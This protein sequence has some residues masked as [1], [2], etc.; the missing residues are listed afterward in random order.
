MIDLKLIEI[1]LLAVL[2]SVIVLICEYLFIF[3]FCKIPKIVKIRNYVVPAT[4][5]FSIYF[6]LPPYFFEQKYL[7]P[8]KIYENW[9]LCS[10]C[11]IAIIW[12][13]GFLI[14]NRIAIKNESKREMRKIFFK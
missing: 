3:K 7:F 6:V 1:V 14:F 13:G 11:F 9:M 5:I 12:G 2:E 10:W 8:E 4:F